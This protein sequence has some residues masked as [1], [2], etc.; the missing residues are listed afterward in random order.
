MQF[1]ESLVFHI[2]HRLRTGLWAGL[3]KVAWG[4]GSRQR[5][6]RVDAGGVPEEKALRV[7]VAGRLHLR[8]DVVKGVFAAQREVLEPGDEHRVPAAELA[9]EV[10]ERAG[11]SDARNG[12]RIVQA[13]L[14]GPEVGGIDHR[15]DAVEV[16]GQSARALTDAHLAGGA[17]SEEGGGNARALRR[18][19]WRRRRRWGSARSRT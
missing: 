16:P 13:V 6:G 5:A 11:D 15:V 3:W 2:F 18:R 1:A 17:Q 7:E 9:A 8:P 10:P 19:R 12:V 14:A 4:L